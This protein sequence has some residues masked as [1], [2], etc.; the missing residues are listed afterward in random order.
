MSPST[1][2]VRV[3]QD[4]KRHAGRGGPADWYAMRW[5]TFIAQRA[6]KR[7]VQTF[8]T[9]LLHTPKHKPHKPRFIIVNDKPRQQQVS[10][11]TEL[12]TTCRGHCWQW[13]RFFEPV[14]LRRGGCNVRVATIK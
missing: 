4:G 3:F 8:H 5:Q 10:F 9:F 12:N 1:R 7:V 11:S 13:H 6:R 14:I 2:S